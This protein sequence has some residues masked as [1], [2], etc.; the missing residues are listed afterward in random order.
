MRYICGK[1]QL[2]QNWYP[3]DKDLTRTAKIDEYLDFHHLNSRM[4]ANLIF[5]T[6]FAKKIGV[7]DP[8]FNEEKAKKNVEHALSC[9][10]SVYLSK[11]DYIVGD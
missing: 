11:G 3:S 5:N 6:L 7:P 1:Y 9:V 2:P 8:S 10:E 4:C